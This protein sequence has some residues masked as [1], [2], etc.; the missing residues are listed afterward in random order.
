MFKKYFK[1]KNELQPDSPFIIQ[2][3]KK[4]Y[5]RVE[6]KYNFGWTEETLIPDIG[7]NDMIGRNFDSS[8]FAVFRIDM[9]N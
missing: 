2:S 3:H 8:N 5:G 6:R 1:N 7:R 4:E 9:L